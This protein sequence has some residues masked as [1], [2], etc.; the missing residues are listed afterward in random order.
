MSIRGSKVSSGILIG[1]EGKK[2]EA[3][4]GSVMF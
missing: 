2:S 3:R 4:T 1:T